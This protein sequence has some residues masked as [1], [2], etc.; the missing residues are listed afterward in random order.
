M[1]EITPAFRTVSQSTAA[2]LLMSHQGDFLGPSGAKQFR[3]VGY[4][5]SLSP[6]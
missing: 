3:K 6:V 1:D 5:L 2:T 4:R